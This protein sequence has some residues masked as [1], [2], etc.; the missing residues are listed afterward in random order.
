MENQILK[1]LKEGYES[2]TAN[3]NLFIIAINSITWD[4]SFITEGEQYFIKGSF[5]LTVEN[6]N[7]FKQ[8][9]APTA[10]LADGTTITL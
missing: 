10:I 5:I 3:N 2:S 6:L 4:D 1:T 8:A 7:P 9:W